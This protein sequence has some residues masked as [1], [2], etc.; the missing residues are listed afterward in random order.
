MYIL[1]LSDKCL[2]TKFI[3][4]EICAINIENCHINTNNTILKYT[5]IYTLRVQKYGN[6]GPKNSVSKMAH[7]IIQ[8]FCNCFPMEAIADVMKTI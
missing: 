2:S 3:V 4:T 8:N 5:N 6:D 7:R 1:S